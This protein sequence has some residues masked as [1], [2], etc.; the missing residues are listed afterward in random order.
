M[1]NCLQ[2]FKGRKRVINAVWA[3]VRCW[4]PICWAAIILSI[5]CLRRAN[6]KRQ[7][8]CS[9]NFSI[10]KVSWFCLLLQCRKIGFVKA[11]YFGSAPEIDK[12]CW[13][14]FGVSALAVL[15]VIDSKKTIFLMWFGVQNSD[16]ILNSSQSTMIE[17]GWGESS[18]WFKN[19][20]ERYLQEIT[21]KF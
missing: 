14:P 16:L 13:H 20:L 12:K 21:R 17:L 19:C 9:A 6:Q 8:H 18:R 15:G 2:T 7:E 5:I 4:L 10:E 3:H 11:S 1:S